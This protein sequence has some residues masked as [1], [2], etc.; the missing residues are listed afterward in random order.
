MNQLDRRNLELSSMVSSD[1]IEVLKSGTYIGGRVVAEFE[2]AF[3]NA[4]GSETAVA[5]ANGLDALTLILQALPRNGKDQVIVPAQTFRATW[6]AVSRAGLE[7]IPVDVDRLGNM[8]PTRL[9][10]ALTTETLAVIVV[11]LHGRPA[12]EEIARVCAGAHVPL[13]EDAA[14]AHGASWCG[15]R[16]GSVGLAAAFSFY[17]TKNLGAVGDAGAVTT[18]DWELAQRVRALANYGEG[19]P[20]LGLRNLESAMNSRMDPIQAVYLRRS[21]PMLD[22]WNGRRRGNA[23]RLLDSVSSNPDLCALGGEL[24][25]DQSV[26]HHFVVKCQE[27]EHL[28]SHLAERGIESQVHYSPPPILDRRLGEIYVSRAFAGDFP[29]AHE[30]STSVLSI[31]VHPWLR[32][33]ELHEIEGALSEYES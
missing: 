10:A 26:W 16:V 3:A 9:G 6:L 30:H 25:G 32:E 29:G 12:S 19:G 20:D 17:P 33:E 5:V 27:R 14:Q 7:P 18:S 21:L 28:R 31:P 1:V 11:H 4:V 8:E 24:D 13:I 23:Q 22:V 15:T 2:H